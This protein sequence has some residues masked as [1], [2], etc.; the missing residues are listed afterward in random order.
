MTAAILVTRLRE[1]VIGHSGNS[2]AVSKGIFD[3]G[4]KF[5]SNLKKSDQ[6]CRNGVDIATGF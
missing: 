1:N 3:D 5:N 4:I 2:I 6:L